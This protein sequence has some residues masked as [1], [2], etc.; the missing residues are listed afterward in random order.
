MRIA[1]GIGAG[2]LALGLGLSACQPPTSFE[3]DAKF[4]NGVKGCRQQCAS[5]GLEM[6]SFIY[7]GAYSTACACRPPSLPGVAPTSRQ[8]EDESGAVA[9]AVAGVEMQRRRAEQQR[10]AA[11]ANHGVIGVPR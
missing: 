4:P 10:A 11:A 9:A 3:G 1:R 2:L 6:G 5:R 8:D 7:I